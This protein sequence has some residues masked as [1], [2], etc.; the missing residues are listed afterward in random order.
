MVLNLGSFSYQTFNNK[1]GCKIYDLNDKELIQVEYCD[2][3]N[4]SEIK[5]HFLLKNEQIRNLRIKLE[6]INIMVVSNFV[7]AFIKS[8]DKS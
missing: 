3:S 7:T 1:V 6:G 5:I 2:I 8:K 4:L